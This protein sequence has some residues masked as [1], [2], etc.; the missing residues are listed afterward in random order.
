L[1]EEHTWY[2]RAIFEK[3][4]EASLFIK[5]EKCDFF[6]ISTSFLGFIVSLEGLSMDS[7]KV[8]II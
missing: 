8:A 1:K 3:L 4:A 2:L 6:T 5:G 7:T